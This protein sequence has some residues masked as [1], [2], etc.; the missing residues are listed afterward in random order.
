MQYP[1]NRPENHN[2]LASAIQLAHLRLNISA[3]GPLM[4]SI[5]PVLTQARP[6]SEDRATLKTFLPSL[7]DPGLLDHHDQ[8]LLSGLAQL[9]E[10]RDVGALPSLGDA[11]LERARVEAAV[12]IAVR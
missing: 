8:R 3:L 5:E 10:G 4:Q 12:A 11:Q 7:N 9:Q 1:E 6:R 2:A